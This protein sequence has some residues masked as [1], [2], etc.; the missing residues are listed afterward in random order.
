MA[1]TLTLSAKA[2]P[3]PFAVIAIASY[4]Q[5]T[6]VVYDESVTGLVLELDGSKLTAE[7]EVVHALAMAAGL[8]DDS[9]KVRDAPHAA[10]RA[11]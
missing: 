5:K 10:D 3:F 1:G 4:T 11:H 8:A 7:D 2:S 6:E 9:A